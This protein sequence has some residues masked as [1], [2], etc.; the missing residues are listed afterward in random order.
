MII[1]KLKT[2]RKQC[3][4]LTTT[5][6]ICNVMVPEQSLLLLEIKVLP[7]HSKAYIYDSTVRQI[8][9][10]ADDGILTDN[11]P[12]TCAAANISLSTCW[13]SLSSL[14]RI[15]SP[16]GEWMDSLL[17]TSCSLCSVSEH[18]VMKRG[19][20]KALD[21]Q[22]RRWSILMHVPEGLFC[23]RSIVTKRQKMYCFHLFSIIFKCGA[24]DTSTAKGQ[25]LC[26]NNDIKIVLEH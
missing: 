10:L 13:Q 26:L 4:Y 6:W 7:S 21:C 15:F 5:Q 17:V 14:S 25:Q 24:T 19:K 23:I 3:N 2:N 16:H 18:I 9:Q 8:A 22:K 1:H 11:L 12:K 20:K